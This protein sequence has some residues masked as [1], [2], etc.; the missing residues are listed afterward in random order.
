M[1]AQAKAL[2]TEE[3]KTTLSR[4][5]TRKQKNSKKTKAASDAENA[6][7]DDDDR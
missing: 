3:D 5:R 4:M 1:H 6:V 2:L 7:R